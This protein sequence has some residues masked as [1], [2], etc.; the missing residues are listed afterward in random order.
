MRTHWGVGIFAG[1]LALS[2]ANCSSRFRDNCQAEADCE[3]GN[4]ADVDACVD[5][6]K[7]EEDVADAYDCGD[8]FGKWA[9]CRENK[10]TCV[11]GKYSPVDC[12]AQRSALS[13]CEEAASGKRDKG[14]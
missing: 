4:D 7:G 11:N 3:G 5:A 8:A 10:G 14:K 12:S 1:V 2:L 13:S 9:D 6:A